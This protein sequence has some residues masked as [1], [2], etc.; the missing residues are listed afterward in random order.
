M[1]V[2]IP[3]TEVWIAMFN[4]ALYNGIIILVLVVLLVIEGLMPVGR[5]ACSR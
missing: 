1:L 3:V 2:L 5:V 4:G